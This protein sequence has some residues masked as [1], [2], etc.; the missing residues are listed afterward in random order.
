VK[1][2]H[3]VQ[4]AIPVACFALAWVSAHDPIVTLVIGTGLTLAAVA[5]VALFRIEIHA[6]R[7]D[8][9]EQRVDDTDA[10]HDRCFADT[11]NEIGRLNQRVFA[12]VPGPRKGPMP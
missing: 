4:V 6:E 11:Y 10:V 7:L 2:R 3:L 5:V 12:R 8:R 9:L 1:R